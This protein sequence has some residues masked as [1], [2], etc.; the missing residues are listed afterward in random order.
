MNG[1]SGE[2]NLAAIMKD[3]AFF[4]SELEHAALDY[5]RHLGMFG[6]SDVRTASS[7]GHMKTRAHQYGQVIDRYKALKAVGR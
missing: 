4:E 7:C 2:D 1:I 5:A 3:L 6:A